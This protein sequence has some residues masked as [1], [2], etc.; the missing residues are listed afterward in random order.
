[1]L[2]TGLKNEIKSIVSRELT[3]AAVKSGDCEVYGTPC[4]AALMEEAAAGLLAPYLEEGK[5]SVGTK[6]SLDHTA[7]TPVGMAVRASAELREIDGRRFVFFI[8]AFD[9]KGLIG[10][11]GHERFIVDREK[12]VGR[13]YGK[14]EEKK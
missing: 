2:K 1:M 5:T 12:F 3:A 10:T 6:L 13:T 8:E 9:E 14:L 4:L 11:A 7:A